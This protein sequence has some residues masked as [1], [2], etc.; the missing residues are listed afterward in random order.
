MHR[1]SAA[2]RTEL[3]YREL[4]RLPLLVLAGGV[5]ASFATVAL[6]TYEIPHLPP[7]KARSQGVTK[8]KSPQWE[9]NP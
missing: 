8:V 3:L 6:K 7:S 4:L 1:V 2:T 9:S 5:V